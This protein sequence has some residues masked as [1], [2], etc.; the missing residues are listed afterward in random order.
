MFPY[1]HMYYMKGFIVKTNTV[2]TL[3]NLEKA[4]M[5]RG[6][7]GKCVNDEHG[8]HECSLDSTSCIVDQS[9]H[10]YTCQC[11][12]GYERKTRT[13][14][15]VPRAK[16]DPCTGKLQPKTFLSETWLIL[17]SLELR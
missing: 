13:A 2:G 1:E 8:C 9:Q 15:M 3:K 12:P 7:I 16:D 4:H 10:G 5:Y 6:S 17:K 11:K 14:C